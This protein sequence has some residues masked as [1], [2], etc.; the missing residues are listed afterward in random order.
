MKIAVLKEKHEATI[1]MALQELSMEFPRLEILEDVYPTTKIQ[2]LISEV[3]KEVIVFTRE[4]TKY[5]SRSSLG[6]SSISTDPGRGY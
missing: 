5:F 6:K 4:C 1:E 3:Y 2:G